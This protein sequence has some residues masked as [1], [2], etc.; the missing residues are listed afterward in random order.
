MQP[1]SQLLTKLEALLNSK[2]GS[3]RLYLTAAGALDYFGQRNRINTL[4]LHKG[5]PF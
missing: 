4:F 1:F 2:V 3:A 5:G